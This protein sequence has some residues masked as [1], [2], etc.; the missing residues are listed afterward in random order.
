M[1]RCKLVSL[2]SKNRFDEGEREKKR[3]RERE[4]ER[5]KLKNN[6]FK[7]LKFLEASPTSKQADTHE[8]VCNI[9][10]L[11]MVVGDTPKIESRLGPC[12]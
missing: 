9:F 10:P 8:S 12:K 2:D 4:R 7:V 6:D 11:F 5:Q 1:I 3:E